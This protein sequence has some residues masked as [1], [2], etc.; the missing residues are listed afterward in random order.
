[1]NNLLENTKH[2]KELSKDQFETLYRITQI[3]NTVEHRDILIENVLDIIINVINAERGIFVK[4]N[5]ENNNF[6]VISARHISKE[7]IENP[8]EFSAG[9]LQKVITEK[10]PLLYH[11]VQGDPNLSQFESVQ[12][13]N[14][15]SVI[16]VPVIKDEQIWGIILAD[17][18]INRQEFTEENLIF[19]NYFSD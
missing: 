4:Y 19:L 16:G 6:N 9:L 14:I 5:E 1:M 17:S 2:I 13:Q 8:H 7:K 18:R 12:I 15:K 11:D 10:K 3:L